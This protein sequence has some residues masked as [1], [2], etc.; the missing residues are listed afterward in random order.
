MTDGVD[1]ARL[2]RKMRQWEQESGREL[3]APVSCTPQSRTADKSRQ[4][5]MLLLKAISVTAMA[6]MQR[7]APQEEVMRLFVMMREIAAVM[8]RA[9]ASKP[10][11]RGRPKLHPSI[12]A[13]SKAN[14]R[15]AQKA[16]RPDGAAKRGPVAGSY[17]RVKSDDDR[18]ALR[19]MRRSMVRDPALKK[20][21]AAYE[22]SGLRWRPVGED[23][24]APVRRLV[25][26]FD[27]AKY[28]DDL[29]RD[30]RLDRQA[31]DLGLEPF[32]L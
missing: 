11:K 2:V 5:Y 7:G 19:A 15:S 22:A 16:K 1:L 20:Y 28:H 27:K 32:W 4:Q 8:P 30:R 18:L 21:K 25:R 29:E 23:H 31:K 26:A 10:V 13:P 14:K 12:L 24:P 9:P 17:R 3:V 6:E